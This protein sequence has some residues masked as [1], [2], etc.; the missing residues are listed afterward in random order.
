MIVKFL[1]ETFLPENP[2][3]EAAFEVRSI[4]TLEALAI[5]SRYTS[6]FE[7][8]SSRSFSQWCTKRKVNL[9]KLKITRKRET[10]SE[11]VGARH[12]YVIKQDLIGSI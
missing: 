4:N 10:G 8:S 3:N 9:M 1:N 12:L 2:F 6:S 5:V 11:K 7:N